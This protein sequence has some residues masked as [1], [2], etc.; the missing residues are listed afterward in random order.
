MKVFVVQ[1]PLLGPDPI[2]SIHSWVEKPFRS[3]ASVCC[4]FQD[5]NDIFFNLE[6][7]VIAVAQQAYIATNPNLTNA[8]SAASGV[9]L[10]AHDAP[11][12]AL[13]KSCSWTFTREKSKGSHITSGGRICIVGHQSTIGLGSWRRGCSEDAF[14]LAA[15]VMH[16]R[17]NSTVHGQ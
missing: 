5:L 12:L 14:V 13:H 7:G 8:V 16:C 6:S 11:A 4:A 10:I 15:L 9:L 17:P 3:S 2:Y 1:F